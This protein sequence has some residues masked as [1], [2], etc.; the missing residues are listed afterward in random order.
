M[1]MAVQ[2]KYRPAGPK[3]YSIVRFG[4]T[5]IRPLTYKPNGDRECWRRRRQ[6][7]RLAAS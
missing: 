5:E 3:C 7:K 2:I 1:K 6:R 4:V